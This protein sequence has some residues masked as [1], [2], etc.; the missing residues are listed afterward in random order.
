MLMV[1]ESFF[2]KTSTE[3]EVAHLYEHIFTTE[4]DNLL[5]SQ[6]FLPYLDYIAG[7]ESIRGEIELNFRGFSQALNSKIFDILSDLD[8]SLR[9]T[10]ERISAA[11]DQI[12]AEK[13]EDVA[14]VNSAIVDKLIA[15]RRRKWREG[16]AIDID[17]SDDTSE[18]EYVRYAENNLGF[19]NIPIEVSYK[20][21]DIEL[22]LFLSRI[23][24]EL[25]CKMISNEFSCSFDGASDEIDQKSVSL[26]SLLIKPDK[27]T[28]RKEMLEKRAEDLMKTLKKS[29][30]LLKFQRQLKKGPYIPIGIDG[31][32]GMKVYEVTDW[33]K[34]ANLLQIK[35]VLNKIKIRPLEITTE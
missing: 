14:Y 9:F 30:N 19:Y 23:V 12:S 27:G 29:K 18:S 10:P 16:V 1:M 7:G 34:F 11:L 3:R 15:V 25:F 28:I 4:L 22:G 6:G 13:R 2:T 32:D 33:A 35:K 24:M 8:K 26:A 21:E 5:I 20:G 17:L 31:V